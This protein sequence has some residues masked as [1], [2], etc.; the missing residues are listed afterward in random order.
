MVAG[1]T[2]IGRPYRVVDNRRPAPL[3]DW[4]GQL[5]ATI[6]HPTASGAR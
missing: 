6:A 3:P 2:V 5:L 4:L 1:P